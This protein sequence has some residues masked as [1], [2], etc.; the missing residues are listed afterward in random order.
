[1]KRTTHGEERHLEENRPTSEAINDKEQA[2]EIYV[3]IE[4]G[5]YIFVGL[6]GRTH[7]F[8]IE[9]LHHTSFRTTTKNRIERQNTGNR[10]SVSREN[11][12]ETLK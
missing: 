10:E 7:I 11:L 12:P 5:Y 1:M 8:T 9:N 3:D 2:T 6:K 4:T